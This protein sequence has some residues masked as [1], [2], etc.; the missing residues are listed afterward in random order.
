MHVIDFV[1]AD[2]ACY[3]SEYATQPSVAHRAEG[4]TGYE[5]NVVCRG[6]VNVAVLCNK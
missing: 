5:I 1:L 6:P 4:R 3:V 2:L